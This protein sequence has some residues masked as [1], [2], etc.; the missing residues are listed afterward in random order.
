MVD[1]TFVDALASKAPT[2]GG[3]GASAMAGALAAALGSM[4][5]HLTIGKK[6]FFDRDAELKEALAALDACRTELLASIDADAEAFAELAVTWKMPKETEEQQLARHRAEQAA[7]DA[8]CAVP[9]QI[10]ET[11]VRVVEIDAYLVRNSARLALSDVGASAALVRA[12][13]EAASLNVF[14]NTSLMDDEEKARAFERD[15]DAMLEKAGAAAGELF[16][17]VRSEIRR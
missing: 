2:P 13:L 15:A 17:F 11:C 4:V 10:M 3:G 6:K 9:L 7:L 8:A 1:R 12:A 5:A 14:I 16:D